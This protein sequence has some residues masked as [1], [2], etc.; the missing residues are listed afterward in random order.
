[1]KTL[2]DEVA[3]LS[4][5]SFLEIYFF[6][7]LYILLDTKCID[8]IHMKLLKKGNAISKPDDAECKISIQLNF[9][10]WKKGQQY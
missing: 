6:S 3:Y 4:L 7:F 9:S 5:I 10:F 2:D 1:M 8:F